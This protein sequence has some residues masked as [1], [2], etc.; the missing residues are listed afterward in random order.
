M[1]KI[2]VV[3]DMKTFISHIM[4]DFRQIILLKKK[5][6][7]CSKQIQ[8]ASWSGKIKFH[9]RTQCSPKNFFKKTQSF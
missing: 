7:K 4:T 1:F 2:L 9:P 5:N 8:V 6:L 3:D